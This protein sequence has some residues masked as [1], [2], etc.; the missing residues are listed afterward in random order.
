MP[1]HDEI[2]AVEVLPENNDQ[3]AERL[4]PEIEVDDDDHSPPM[5]PGAD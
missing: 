2:P 4:R 5:A 1:L 3:A